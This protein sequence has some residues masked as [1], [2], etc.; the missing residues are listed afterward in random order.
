MTVCIL[1]C[2][3]I[4]ATY[5]SR[6]LKAP[7]A[8]DRKN[9]L[10]W[11]IRP[12]RI[13]QTEMNAMQF[14]MVLEILEGTFK[15]PSKKAGIK[16]A[17]LCEVSRRIDDFYRLAH[18]DYMESLDTACRMD[19]ATMQGWYKQ[20]GELKNNARP[21]AIFLGMCASAAG[22]ISI[23]SPSV[24]AGHI[25]ATTCTAG[26]ILLVDKMV[27]QYIL[28]EGST[29]RIKWMFEVNS[30]EL[31]RFKLSQ[32]SI[33]ERILTI[34]SQQNELGNETDVG[35]AKEFAQLNLLKALF[36]AAS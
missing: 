6:E 14:Q 21:F 22:I 34:Q 35:L 20:Y 2:Q 25:L 1:F 11:N 28:R 29:H 26:A 7:K 9:S 27:D 24:K 10:D 16:E 5:E 15:L 30:K 3:S 17:E 36:E 32:R 19:E 18:Q 33:E 31:T 12:V 4:P 8:Q 23:I 13:T